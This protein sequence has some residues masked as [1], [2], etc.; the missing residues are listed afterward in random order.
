MEKIF[1]ILLAVLIIFALSFTSCDKDDKATGPS[2]SYIATEEWNSIV[3]QGTGSGSWKFSMKADSSVIV[4]GEWIYNID[5]YG[6]NYEIKCPYT[7]GQATISGSS[8]SF[9]A[10]GTAKFTADPSQTS[11]FTFNIE[12]TTDNG[13]GSGTYTISFTAQG[14]PPQLSGSWTATRTSGSGITK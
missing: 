8:L 6:T 9:T 10:S 14:W 12:G 1:N 3:D 5:L 4:D 7:D 11:P 13:Q 2:E